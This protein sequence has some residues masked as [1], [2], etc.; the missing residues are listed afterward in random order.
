MRKEECITCAWYYPGTGCKSEE[1]MACGCCYT[2]ISN[3]ERVT[4][5]ID[6]LD[7]CLKVLKFLKLEF[8]D[9]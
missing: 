6:I 9:E 7:A 8:R 4:Q 3:S 5:I 1:M 2:P